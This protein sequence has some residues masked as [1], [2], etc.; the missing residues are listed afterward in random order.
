MSS[1][2]P[3]GDDGVAEPSVWRN[4]S[5]ESVRESDTRLDYASSLVVNVRVSRH[6]N[7]GHYH[8]RKLQLECEKLS[9]EIDAIHRE[10]FLK[11]AAAWAAVAVPILVAIF[12]WRLQSQF[13]RNA[14][15]QEY[16][17]TSVGILASRPDT[18]ADA[19]RL[20][21][22]A[23]KLLDQYSP[24]RLPES[25]QDD[26]NN[27]KVRLPPQLPVSLPFTL[28]DDKGNIITDDRGNAIGVNP[29]PRATPTNGPSRQ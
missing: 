7:S 5:V 28:S 23:T 17:R 16:V 2:R 12:G 25:V 22:W 11:L 8:D 20:R 9:A 6:T 4:A 24:V 14:T 18:N 3:C 21:T 10:R 27:G 15:A 26:L 29:P 1:S 13:A 19:V